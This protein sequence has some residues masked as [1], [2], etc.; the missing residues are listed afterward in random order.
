MSARLT[1]D[2]NRLA[3]LFERDRTFGRQRRQAQRMLEH[4][5]L[6]ISSALTLRL[7]VETGDTLTDHAAVLALF[8]DV[9]AS[10]TARTFAVFGIES[11]DSA[12]SNEERKPE[13]RCCRIVSFGAF[14]E[15]PKGHTG[16]CEVGL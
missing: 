7:P 15:H 3:Q 12:A 11:S 9:V 4:L 8:R 1:P 6:M 2:G 10:E 16:P 14:C 13:E 5:Q